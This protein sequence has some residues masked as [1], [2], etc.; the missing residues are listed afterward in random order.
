MIGQDFICL[1]SLISLTFL[2]F[3]ARRGPK[4]YNITYVGVWIFLYFIFKLFLTF[5]SIG[6]SDKF[7]ILFTSKEG[8]V[9]FLIFNLI[10]KK[11][12]SFLC[13]VLLGKDRCKGVTCFEGFL[14]VNIYSTLCFCIPCYT[15]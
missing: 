14:V 15:H 8:W 13:M 2:N 1:F 5:F 9:S 4:A 11:T 7:V 12:K 6:S 3:F 10:S